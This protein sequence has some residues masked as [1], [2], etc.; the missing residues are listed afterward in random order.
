M[1]EGITGVINRI[2][3]IKGRIEEIKSLEKRLTVSPL[4]KKPGEEDTQN[5]T[6]DGKS[7]TDVLKQV[8]NENGGLPGEDGELSTNR[9]NLLAGSKNDSSELL[10]LLYKNLNEKN[11]STDINKTIDEAS[12]G[13]GIDKALIKAVIKQE[14]GFDPL[15]T[16]N[17]GAM[18]LMQL[19]PQTAEDLGVKNPYDIR[20]NIFG[21]SKYLKEMLTRFKGDLNLALAAY[22]AGPNAVTKHGGIPPYE[23]T[24]NYVRQVMKFYNEFKKFD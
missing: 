3:E 20:Q 19:M 5:L 7:F 14:S 9:L 1:I 21:G 10:Q 17:K 2:G 8:L 24:Q 22:N 4:N 12:S 13:L 11:K 16:S 6:A 15:A 18:G 23:E